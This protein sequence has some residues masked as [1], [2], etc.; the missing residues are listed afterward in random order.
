[1]FYH[2]GNY[3]EAYNNIQQISNFENSGQIF[4]QAL[5]LKDSGRR[6]EASVLL[7][8]IIDTFPNDDYT[9]YAKNLLIEYND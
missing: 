8:Q 3:D 2:L 6:D 9:D 5:I 1:M 4:L 7:K